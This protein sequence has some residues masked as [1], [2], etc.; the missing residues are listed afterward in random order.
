MET[1]ELAKLEGILM[2]Y[3]DQN[4]FLPL[5]RGNQRQEKENNCLGGNRQQEEKTIAL[6]NYKI[7]ANKKCKSNMEV[8]ENITIAQSHLFHC[9]SPH[10]YTM[11]KY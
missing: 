7:C 2:K 9:L 3:K 6:L 1:Y 4:C 5:S 8:K 10:Q 11:C